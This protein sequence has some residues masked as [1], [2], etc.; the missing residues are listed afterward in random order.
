MIQQGGCKTYED[1]TTSGCEEPCTLDWFTP[2]D[3]ITCET[4]PPVDCT[5]KAMF[6]T[7]DNSPTDGKLT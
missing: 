4:E 3:Y 2:P 5:Y 6:D 7:C 1:G